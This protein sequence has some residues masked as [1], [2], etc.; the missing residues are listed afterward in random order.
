MTR[1]CKHHPS[2]HPPAQPPKPPGGEVVMRRWPHPVEPSG[3]PPE[4]LRCQL[5]R[6]TELLLEIRS[7]L[8]SAPG[9]PPNKK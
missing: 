2:G 3:V 6:Q 4:E 9:T 5:Q 8:E 7:L 1:P